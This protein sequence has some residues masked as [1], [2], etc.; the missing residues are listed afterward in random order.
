VEISVWS[1]I[2][3]LGEK[4]ANWAEGQGDCDTDMREDVAYPTG[5][6][7]LGWPFKVFCN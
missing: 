7:D 2:G 5:L 3:R 6:L 1:F 4:E